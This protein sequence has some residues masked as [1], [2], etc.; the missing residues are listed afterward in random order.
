[1]RRDLES[2]FQRENW[3]RQH[4][5]PYRRAVATRVAAVVSQGPSLGWRDPGRHPPGSRW[6]TGSLPAAFRAGLKESFD[7]SRVAEGVD[8]GGPGDPGP[9]TTTNWSAGSQGRAGTGPRA[10][11]TP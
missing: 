6:S 11:A 3:F 8:P 5:L 7:P 2:F 4:D 10:S 9:G 1:M